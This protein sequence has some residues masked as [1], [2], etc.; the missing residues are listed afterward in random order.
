VRELPLDLIRPPESRGGDDELSLR[1][2]LVAVRRR[3]FAVLPAFL[4]VLALGT[5]RTL[6]E[7]RRY[8]AFATV[9]V[10]QQRPPIPGVPSGYS[11]VDYRYDA[12]IAEQ[13]IIGSS[14][15]A[16]LVADAEGMRLRIAEPANARRSEVFGTTPPVVD[17]AATIAEYELRFEDRAAI[18]RS[19][20]REVA[21]APYGAP[22][23]YGGLS[24]TVPSRPRRISQDH[25]VLE[26]VSRDVAAADILASMGTT[27][28][29]KTNIIEISYV[30][31]DPVTVARVTNGI[32]TA[33]EEFSKATQRA[34]QR[35]K[36]TFIRDNLREQQDSLYR[37][38]DALRA[39]KE[40]NR[41]TDVTAEQAALQSRIAGFETAR[42]EAVL[43]QN[44]FVSLLERA[45]ETS[46]TDEELRR[47]M[48]TEAVANNSSI[49]TLYDRWFELEKDRQE[50]ITARGLS[51]KHEDVIAIDT[52]INR[53]K[54]DLQQASNVYLRGLNARIRQYDE[55][56]SQLRMQTTQFPGLSATEKNLEGRV[57]SMQKIYDDLQQ[58]Y[59]V[60]R[61][62]QS[63]DASKVEI[64]DEAT[65]PGWPVSPNRKRDV[66]MAAALGLLLGV[67]IAVVLDRLD[68]SIRSPDEVREQLDVNVLGMIPVIRV[69]HD[70]SKM[71]SDAP[72]ERLVTHADPRSVVAE[73][74]RSLRTN[75]A[76]AR[77][78]QDVRTLVLTSPGP[79]DGKSTTVANL[80]ITFAQQGQRT[81]LIDADLRRA[82]LDKTF[83]VPR[84][85]GLTELI[86]GS[87]DLDQAVHETQ[88][89]NLFV[90]GSGQFPP[91]PSELLGSPAMREILAE[92]KEKFDVVLFDS[93]PLLAVTDAAVL[94][95]MVDGTVLVV[96]MGS[97]A[98]EAARLAIARLRQVHARVLGALLNDVH[99]RGPGYYGGYGYQYYAYYGSEAN[100]NG[101]GKPQGMMGRIRELT[102]IGGRDGR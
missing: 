89:P 93:P 39:F 102:G 7:P 98:R 32:A 40:G 90:M 49:K 74:Y 14:A 21:R 76:F 55:Q 96:R 95:T 42:R 65:V 27:V 57:R 99:M 101:N 43:E 13:R 97:T 64:I 67:L 8:R 35:N 11:A 10:Q 20:D 91:N 16:K 46:A 85:P 78:S 28:Q 25:V 62:E 38:Q 71:P 19:A 34:E 84:S 24:F 83:S 66:M 51:P 94:S 60:S 69:D 12:M 92:A 81:L 88:V 37:A 31:T 79:A 82:V 1:R 63:V 23:A 100:G 59:Q 87:V 54:Q 53:T 26:V 70:Q 22:I 77:A 48:G 41:L 50:R 3:W 73:S 5:W 36:I 44:I 52:M 58:Q 80:A 86:I 56:L 33:Y 72:L 61:I 15:V 18:L 68:N 29:E 75:L 4:V 2:V 6:H 17:N 45:D 9:R 47:I 30:G